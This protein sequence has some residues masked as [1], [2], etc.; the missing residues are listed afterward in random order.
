LLISPL[1]AHAAAG[2]GSG[3]PP[4]PSDQD[5]KAA[6]RRAMEADKAYRQGLDRIPDAK[7]NNDPWSKVR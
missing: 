5:Q 3:P 4:A 1:A 7:P 6:A 2:K